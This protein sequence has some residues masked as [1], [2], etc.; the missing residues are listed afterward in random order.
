MVLYPTPLLAESTLLFHCVRSGAGCWESVKSP[1]RTAE[2]LT[3]ILDQLAVKM[4]DVVRFES[5][6]KSVVRRGVVVFFGGEICQSDVGTC[7]ESSDRRTRLH[8]SHSR[9]YI[10][11]H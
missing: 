8:L 7:Q 10:I 11:R 1:S 2:I 4:S 3:C 6:V 5:T 9:T